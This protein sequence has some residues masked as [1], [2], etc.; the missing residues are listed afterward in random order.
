MSHNDYTLL[1][2]SLVLIVMF[3]LVAINT[4]K[5]KLLFKRKSIAKPEVYKRPKTRW[6][7]YLPAKAYSIMITT[8]AVAQK[9]KDL[10]KLFAMLQDFR[11]E[12]TGVIPTKDINAYCSDINTEKNDRRLDLLAGIMSAKKNLSTA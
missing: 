2:T 12:F 5:I 7:G 9:P 10:D 11:V 4:D 8:I 1:V 3:G 6:A